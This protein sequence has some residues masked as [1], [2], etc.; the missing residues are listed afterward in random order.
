M[1]FFLLQSRFVFFFFFFDELLKIN[2]FF[3]WRRKI[4]AK[5]KINFTLAI[6]SKI[7]IPIKS[8]NLIRNFEKHNFFFFLLLLNKLILYNPWNHCINLYIFPILPQ[9][10]RWFFGVKKI[11]L[12]FFLDWIN[13]SKFTSYGFTFWM[14]IEQNDWCFCNEC[15]FWMNWI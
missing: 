8:Q 6:P 13:F 3:F 2:I 11:F 4:K 1:I 9:Y 12:I 7:H 14:Y 5:K 10:L 15:I